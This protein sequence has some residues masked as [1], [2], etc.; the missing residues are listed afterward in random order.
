M[1]QIIDTHTHFFDPQ[2][3]QGVPWPNPD[4]PDLYR[5]T[6]PEH[7][8]D[9]AAGHGVT[10]T[11]VV[12]ASSWLEDNQWILD[13]ADDPQLTGRTAIAGFVG[14]VRNDDV[15][16]R[17][18]LDRFGA[19]PL[20]RGIRLGNDA[21]TGRG[22]AMLV[23]TVR[24]LAARELAL[25]VVP[26]APELPALIDLC[27]AVPEAHVVIDHVGHVR[28]DGAAPDPAWCEGMAVL[29]RA[30]HVYCK[31]SGL[32]ENAV[33]AARRRRTSASTSPRWTHS[34]SASA[35]SACCTPATGRSAA[36]AAR[37]RRCSRSR[38]RTWNGMASR[39]L[40]AS[41]GRTPSLPTAC[42]LCSRR[43]YTARSRSGAP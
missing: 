38:R 23:D 13:L 1:A 6:L 35:P 19:H 43:P 26:G 20:F 25:D 3:P 21:V 4:N 36:R 28:I 37:T 42:P 16:F 27:D 7:L 32:V 40:P 17:R 34:G 24:E 12:E 8:L 14:N 22:R 30:P 18:H 2:R 9:V 39:P 41:F 29:A 11:V 10:H 31:I 5:T 33:P 15:D